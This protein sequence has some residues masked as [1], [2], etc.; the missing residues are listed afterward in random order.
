M[1]SCMQ[2]CFFFLSFQIQYFV[3]LFFFSKSC[4]FSLLFS[5]FK[6]ETEKKININCNKAKTLLLK[7]ISIQQYNLQFTIYNLQFVYTKSKQLL[8]A[9]YWYFILKPTTKQTDNIFV[10][11]LKQKTGK[12]T[13]VQLCVQQQ[14]NHK[15]LCVQH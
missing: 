12:I 13:L 5:S 8:S 7:F 14:T 15:Q 3:H 1:I 4:F 10:C 6:R 9:H 2:I 11:F